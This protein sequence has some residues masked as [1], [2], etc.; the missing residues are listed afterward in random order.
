MRMLLLTVRCTAPAAVA[1]TAA[2]TVRTLR[3]LQAAWASSQVLAVQ[4]LR[5]VQVQVQVQVVALE[6]KTR[7]T[8]PCRGASAT[9]LLGAAAAR[10]QAPS[11]QAHDPPAPPLL[12]L[13]LL[14]PRLFM[15]QARLALAATA[16]HSSAHP[17]QARLQPTPVL[18]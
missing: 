3:S 9:S 7:W 16:A 18:S 13:L 2:Q 15:H 6:R 8:Q 5:Q 10:G 14:P 1:A 11:A 17:L 12:Q 4:D